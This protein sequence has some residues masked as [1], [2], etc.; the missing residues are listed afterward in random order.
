M[1]CTFS[2]LYKFKKSH[3]NFLSDH[4]KCIWLLS[5]NKV[6]CF[7]IF[8]HSQACGVSGTMLWKN[9][10]IVHHPQERGVF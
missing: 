1:N 9:S 6:L 8:T 3:L 4:Q 10:G 5:I 2:K 7:G